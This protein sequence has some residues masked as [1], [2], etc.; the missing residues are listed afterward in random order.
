VFAASTC[1]KRFA[2]SDVPCERPERGR[3][4]RGVRDILRPPPLPHGA[5]AAAGDPVRPT[6]GPRAGRSRRS[7]AVWAVAGAPAADPAGGPRDYAAA[8]EDRM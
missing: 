4:A 8:E 2:D 7:G 5:P 6:G 3:Q 1:R